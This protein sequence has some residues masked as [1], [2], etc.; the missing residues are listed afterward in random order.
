[1]SSY[2]VTLFLEFA[3]ERFPN[4]DRMIQEWTEIALEAVRALDPISEMNPVFSADF[5]E[6]RAVL[7]VTCAGTSVQ[8]FFKDQ[9][10]V[11]RIGAGAGGLMR[12]VPLRFDIERCTWSTDA[13][14]LRGAIETRSRLRPVTTT[15]AIAWTVIALL[16]EHLDA[17][18]PAIVA[19]VVLQP[20]DVPP[21]HVSHAR[22]GA[23]G[24]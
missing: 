20:S 17:R 13:T 10:I 5:D 18:S 16:K 23:R 21:L 14:A 19:P 4:V 11:A 22:R 12:E 3:H 6:E 24:A 1:M 7:L 8:V 9:Q 2:A 15:D